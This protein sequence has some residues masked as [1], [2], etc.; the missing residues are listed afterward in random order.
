MKMIAIDIDATDTIQNIL[1][2]VKKILV[3]NGIPTKSPTVQCHCSKRS[4]KFKPFGKLSAASVKTTA[5]IVRRAMKVNG[6][7]VSGLAR[8]FNVTPGN[9]SN[10]KHGRFRP[11]AEK[12]SILRKMAY[13]STAKIGKPFGKQCR[14]SRDR[15]AKIIQSI[16]KKNNLTASEMAKKFHVHTTTVYGWKNGKNR[17]TRARMSMITSMI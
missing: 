10:W 15:T 6:L 17:P 2:E 1:T 11:T 4:G 7:S 8:R 9:V 12:L 5:Q 3:D 16:M 14:S 13:P